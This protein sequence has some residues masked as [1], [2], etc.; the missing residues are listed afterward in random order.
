MLTLHPLGTSDCRL[1]DYIQTAEGEKLG[2]FS[3][4]G[5]NHLMCVLAGHTKY[6]LAPLPPPPHP[7]VEGGREGG[8]SPHQ[9]HLQM[10]I[11]MT[12]CI[13]IYLYIYSTHITSISV[14]TVLHFLETSTSEL[15]SIGNIAEVV[16]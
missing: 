2:D 1:L 15:R 14:Y 13:D 9:G 7:G 10:S 8:L 3:I 4:L 5:S 16:K 12:N 6:V 11:C